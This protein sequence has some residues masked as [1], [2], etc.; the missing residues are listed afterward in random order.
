MPGRTP[1]PPAAATAGA[2]WLDAHHAGPPSSALECTLAA[3]P[4][5]PPASTGFANLAADARRKRDWPKIF[6]RGD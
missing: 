5:E 1:R 6:K 3:S 4:A 2:E